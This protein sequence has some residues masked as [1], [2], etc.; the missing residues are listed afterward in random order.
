MFVLCFGVKEC[1]KRGCRPHPG[2]L[3]CFC[4][5]VVV[6]LFPLL[7]FLVCLSCVCASVRACMHA[8][9][10]SV[11]LFRKALA[12]CKK[13]TPT[14]TFVVY[15][16]PSQSRPGDRCLRGGRAGGMFCFSYPPVHA[17][18]PYVRARLFLFL[19]SG[20]SIPLCLLLFWMLGGWEGSAF[21]LRD[22][23]GRRGR[24]KLILAGGYCTPPTLHRY[25]WSARK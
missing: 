25:P 12:L 21:R 15:T 17:S 19:S 4:M 14:P 3:C 8:S 23:Q 10:F 2:K 6:E 1:V 16:A 22:T 20:L 5:S 7:R 18:F 9:R 11:V 24:G 13:K